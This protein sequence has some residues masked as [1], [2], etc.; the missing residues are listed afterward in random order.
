MLT[1]KIALDTN[2]PEVTLTT[3][4]LDDS[5]DMLNGEK[6]PAVIICPGGSYLFC[7]DKEGEPIALRFAAMG[8][9]AFVLHYHTYLKSGEAFET[10]F[11][12]EGMKE[13][14]ENN[15]PAPIH[16]IAQSMT[17]IY[18]HAE[19]W[20]VDTDKIALCGFSAGGHNVTNYAVHWDKPVVTDVFD[21]NKVKPAA[22][23]AGYPLTDYLFM[24]ETVANQIQAAQNLFVASC[25]SFLGTADPSDE[26]LLE[27]SPARLIDHATPP[28]FIWATAQ[29]RL[30]PVAHSTRLV[31]GLAEAGIPFESH[32]FE[33]GDHGL[34]LA[35]QAVAGAQT[36]INT[37]AAKWIDLADAWLLKR[38]KISLPEKG[39]YG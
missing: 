5:P 39:R 9:H 32:I 26:L 12:E 37:D 29:D 7:S 30:L 23:I 16:D 28:M 18:D 35:T 22:I 24:K 17:M 3:Y 20:L 36:E 4:L 33:D 21:V 2:N 13:R 15:Y 27:V 1:K 8:Y 34:S 38:F 6:R 19:E 25:Y 11:S 31:D 14:P 10:I